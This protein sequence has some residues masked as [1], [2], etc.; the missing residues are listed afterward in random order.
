M[1]AAADAR[2]VATTLRIYERYALEVV[3][4][5]NLCPWAEKARRTGR[6]APR[7]LLQRDAALEPSLAL[8]REL[9]ADPA[10]EIALLLF[11]RF[12]PGR[13]A[14]DRF[15]AALREADEP[16]WELGQ[17]P[18]A[19]AA[20]H[21]D[22]PLDATRAERL[23]PFIRRTPDPTIQL[24]R[25]TV[26]DEVRKGPAEGTQFIDLSTF[27]LEQLPPADQRSLRERIATQNQERLERFGYQRFDALLADIKAERDRLHAELGEAPPWS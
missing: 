10:T 7:V 22:A 18:F 23:V 5:L 13:R 27:S 21:Y 25:R 9:A 17:V 12:D 2:L 24:V 20:F 14:F 3:E 1:S 11:P 26:L 4:A 8:V 6:V 19:M 15:V 16:H